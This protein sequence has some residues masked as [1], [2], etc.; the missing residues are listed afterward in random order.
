MFAVGRPAVPRDKSLIAGHLAG[1]WV[2]RGETFELYNDVYVVVGTLPYDGV[3]ID[4]DT[5]I[6]VVGGDPVQLLRDLAE[7]RIH[8]EAVELVADLIFY[9]KKH[10]D[11][12]EYVNFG[13][14]ARFSNISYSDFARTVLHWFEEGIIEVRLSREFEKLFAA[15]LPEKAGRGGVGRPPPKRKSILLSS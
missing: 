2:T 9:K 4:E 13:R 3:R 1:R 14:T 11:F 12:V 5:V 8:P 15:I 10:E 7:N 6:E